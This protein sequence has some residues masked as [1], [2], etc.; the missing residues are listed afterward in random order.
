MESFAGVK[1]E[2]GE[3]EEDIRSGEEI[4]W[5]VEKKNNDFYLVPSI[6][7]GYEMFIRGGDSIFIGTKKI[8]VVSSTGKLDFIILSRDCT[9]LNS[10]STL[11]EYVFGVANKGGEDLGL[12][13]ASVKLEYN[14]N[15]ILVQQNS[16]A[17]V[18]VFK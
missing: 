3:I 14:Y 9:T 15:I 17:A 12:N 6:T 7:R 11:R 18:V 2:A 10:Y 8:G 5:K 16:A 13:G 4:S 1:K